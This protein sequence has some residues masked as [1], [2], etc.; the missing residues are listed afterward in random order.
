MKPDGTSF[1]EARISPLQIASGSPKRG[2]G[3]ANSF[4]EHKGP[5]RREPATSIKRDEAGLV[6]VEMQ[7]CG[8]FC[9]ESAARS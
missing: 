5:G 7:N 4:F 2:E 8:Y 9:A 6:P 1:A 3:V